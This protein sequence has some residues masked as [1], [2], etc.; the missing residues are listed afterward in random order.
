MATFCGGCM[1]GDIRYEIDGEPVFPHVC[2][3]WK[4]RLWSGAPIVGWADFPLAG[5]QWTGR[6]GWPT[7][8]RES[9]TSQRG[10]CPRCG[11]T[12]CAMDDGSDVI[13]ITT[14]SLDDS[15]SLRPVSHSFSGDL[16]PWLHVDLSPN[17]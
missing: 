10:F 9:E 5:L 16:V 14:S 3:C 6:R 2:S 4:C 17:E 11:G 15:S 7:L 1:C 13:G 12:L 8:Y